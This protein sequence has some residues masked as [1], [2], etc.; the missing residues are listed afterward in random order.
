MS[1]FIGIVLGRGFESPLG[2]IATTGEAYF[3]R[4]V[5]LVAISTLHLRLPCPLVREAGSK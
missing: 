1:D 2:Q 5:D 3:Y 4:Q